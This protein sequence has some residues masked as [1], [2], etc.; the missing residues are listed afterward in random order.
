MKGVLHVPDLGAMRLM[1]VGAT[2][3]L[4]C[5]WEFDNKGFKIMLKDK[6]IVHGG[7]IGKHLYF[8]KSLTIRDVA[9]VAKENLQV[10]HER[11][12]H[13]SP[14]TVKVMEKHGVV[15]GLALKNV[16]ETRQ[17][18][19][20]CALG[21]MA[22]K[23]FHE[24]TNK[25]NEVGLRIH[26][27]LCGPMEVPSLG[28]SRYMITFKDE[29][30][31][32]RVVFF[33]VS[34][35]EVLDCMK[36]FV[37]LQKG[38]C[39]GTMA[40][41]LRTD[42][43]TEYTNKEFE[44]YLVTNEIVHERTAAG[45]PE[46]NGVAERENRII[47]EHARAMLKAKDLPKELWAE[48]MNT[49]AYAFNRI[50]LRGESKMP[51]E[52][53]TGKKPDVSHMR[54]FGTKG[55]VHVP[56]ELRKKLDDKSKLMVF[57]GYT[58][59]DKIY[60]MWKEGTKSLTSHRDVIFDMVTEPSQTLRVFEE[61]DTEPLQQPNVK[62]LIET[63]NSDDDTSRDSSSTS[64]EKDDVSGI[65]TEQPK[66]KGRPKGAKNK[67]YQR[68]DRQLR[69]RTRLYL[70]VDEPQTMDEA[71]RST[72]AE[73]W[74]VAMDDEIAP[75]R[76]NNTYVLV[77]LP[78]GK[79]AI[80]CR[81]LF[82]LKE[83]PDGSMRRYKARLVAKG[84]TQRMGIDYKET[85]APVVNK[86]SVR[87][88][89]AIAAVKDLEIVH[90]DVKTAFLY[91]ELEEELYMKQPEGYD[92]NPDMVCKLIKSL[93]GLKQSPRMWNQKFSQF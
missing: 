43:G 10:W 52:K 66:T 36:K 63:T 57:V 67:V 41:F 12:A 56:K 5:K 3:R 23:P 75:L 53:W 29:A 89:L 31:A 14:A 58:S 38:M 64:E 87:M 91:G 65:Q 7:L 54:V 84:Y 80:Y 85:Y 71:R 19:K 93:Y 49:A 21:K 26:S 82:K 83:K 28:G 73:K 32:Y 35:T 34:K 92:D 88:I 33:I 18:C 4:G 86:D 59:M 69:P 37:A 15:T 13:V 9:C 17:V 68:M 16:E 24:N 60:Q 81:W 77:Q 27:D 11:L 90:F 51:F 61:I 50:S 76:K 44:N 25:T 72:D 42:N 62:E 74:K 30:S 78:P 1:S 22:K 70:A 2:S 47:V 8:M 55:Y 46:Q 39:K 45:N 48:A 20:G 6:C 79:R 40:K